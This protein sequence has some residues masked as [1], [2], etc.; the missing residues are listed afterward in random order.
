MTTLGLYLILDQMILSLDMFASIMKFGIF[1]KLNCKSIVNRRGMKNFKE[2]YEDDLTWHAF[3]RLFKKKYLSER[4]YDDRAKEFY[5][6]QMGSMSNEE[7]TRIFLELLRYV[8]Y[9][10]EEKTEVHR[11][12]SGF[13]VSYRDKIEFDE[14]RSLEEAIRKLKHCY[15]QSKRRVDPNHDLKI[16]EKATG[17]WPPNRVRTQDAS[18]KYNVVP[19]KRFNTAEKGH[20]EQQARGGGR[21]PLQCWIC[22]KDHRKRDCS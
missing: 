21:E 8:P 12:I 9:L 16:I 18:E 4:Y 10:R 14:P 6:L 11:Y 20:G 22:G 19:Y 3:E 7:Y 5:E 13:S 2:I 17:K 15:E 1:G